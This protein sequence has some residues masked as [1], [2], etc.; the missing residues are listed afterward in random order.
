[1]RLFSSLKKKQTWLFFS[2]LFFILLLFSFASVQDV[3]GQSA[4]KTIEAVQ[5]LGSNSAEAA[6]GP[7]GTTPCP[8]EGLGKFFKTL[9]EKIMTPQVKFIV[10]S[11]VLDTFQY[12]VDRVAQEAAIAIASGG[13]GQTP[14]FQIDS[15]QELLE[16]LM[17]D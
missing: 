17:A 6:C 8:P 3:F 14:L 1:M 12:A 13:I 9:G 10:F 16:T 2:S 15:G 7:K 5:E 4:T 11:T